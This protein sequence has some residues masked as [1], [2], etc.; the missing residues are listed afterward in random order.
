MPDSKFKD[1]YAQAFLRSQHDRLMLAGDPPNRLLAIPEP[2]L[3]FTVSLMR[4]RRAVP[5]QA[6]KAQWQEW[7]AVLSSHEVLPMMHEKSHHLPD[8]EQLPQRVRD[9]L[10]Q[11]FMAA[12]VRSLQVE[13]QLAQILP[14]MTAARLPCLVM[15]GPAISGSWYPNPA[16]RP[17][18]DI[19]LLVPRDRFLQA[20]EIL[21]DMGYVCKAP[22]FDSTPDLHSEE[23]FDHLRDR[24]ALP[25]ELHWDIHHFYGF[26]GKGTI[27]DLF[28]RSREKTYGSVTFTGLDPVDELIHV[29][30]HMVL[31][32]TRDIRLIWLYDIFLL[33]EEIRRENLW[34]VFMER[35]MEWRAME[36]ARHLL[37]LTRL[38]SPLY[39]S[40]MAKE[41]L[42]WTF[43]DPE[44]K[45]E[46]ERILTK[47]KDARAMISLRLPPS[48]SPVRKYF[49][50]ARFLFPPRE[51][52]RKRY[53]IAHDGLLPFYYILRIY[54]RLIRRS[55]TR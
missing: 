25:V 29:I 37:S 42:R 36:A 18:N 30:L 44:E 38:W 26:R 43:P 1:G 20:R 6:S 7:L 33:T 2:L 50:L 10:R 35:C 9:S 17:H 54:E 12:D 22:R 16:L 28:D 48:L 41:P 47:H 3:E 4:G 34:Q 23:S 55:W 24:S 15:K 39:T 21:C 45:K 51:N 11:A 14:M 27:E 19:D 5:P 31:I 52:L 13:R 40:D 49:Y 8:G 46:W 32:H 53:R